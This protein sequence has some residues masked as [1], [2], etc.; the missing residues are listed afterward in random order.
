MTALQTL[1]DHKKLVSIMSFIIQV[2]KAKITLWVVA[3]NMKSY[4]FNSQSR[5]QKVRKFLIIMLTIGFDSEFVFMLNFTL[6]MIL[7]S[8]AKTIVIFGYIEELM[9]ITHA[10][11]K[12]IG[13][14]ENQASIFRLANYFSFYDKF[15]SYKYLN[16]LS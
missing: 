9:N 11:R 15:I 6:L 1:K 3:S 5:I 2:A 4:D 12:I 14:T 16:I 13:Q 10:E 8:R 7:T